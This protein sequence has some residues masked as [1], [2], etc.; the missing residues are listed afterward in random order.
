VRFSEFIF[1][2]VGLMQLLERKVERFSGMLTA[3]QRFF[4]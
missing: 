2:P 3:I 1:E 4:F